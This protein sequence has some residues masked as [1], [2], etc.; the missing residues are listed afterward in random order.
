MARNWYPRYP[1]DYG[2]DTG[3]LTLAQHGAYT[4][5]LDHY[6]TRGKALPGDLQALCRLLRATSREEA[7]AVA[8]VLQEFFTLQGDGYHQA[9]SDRELER[10]QKISTVRSEL[11]AK[12][13]KT[14]K[15][16][17]SNSQA[18]ASATATAIAVANDKPPQP[19]LQIQLEP[20]PEPE[21][22]SGTKSE[23]V[24]TAVG[25]RSKSNATTKGTRWPA[26]AIVPEDW[27]SDA[28]AARAAAGLPRVD[29]TAEAAAFPHYWAGRG[30][31]EA[32]K[33][34][35]R[36]TWINRALTVNGRGRSNGSGRVSA[37]DVFSEMYVQARAEREASES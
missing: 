17:Q 2:R 23:G 8:S 26:D 31:R 11:G 25:R 34:D 22:D 3:H 9:R 35:W 19:Q 15:Q 16:K 18:I 30:G 21:P 32:L 20:E 6:Y 5:L 36:R 12:G 37:G 24:I 33:T 13:A 29:L 14:K 4:L 1:G 10:M 27:I 28:E 7:R